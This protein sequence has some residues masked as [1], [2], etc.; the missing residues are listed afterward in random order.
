MEDIIN[1]GDINEII[2]NNIN[3]IFD[4][5]NY[6]LINKTSNK[7]FKIY[8]NNIKID[9]IPVRTFIN[10]TEC[11]VCDSKSIPL[12]QLIYRY[13]LVPHKCLIHCDKKKCYLSVVK[14][15]LMDIKKKNIYPFCKFT[16]QFLE[17]NKRTFR[18]CDE[19]NSDYI[20]INS[21]KKYRS[22]WYVKY[23]FKEKYY[24]IYSVD[25]LINYNLFR[26]FLK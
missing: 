5:L 4:I 14:R 7:I 22:K 10:I 21:L 18:D 1:I 9:I 24:K 25:N 13:D 20:H 3:T 2:F 17:D 23:N 26:W 11:N 8:F 16:D 6:R 19:K 12:K 15:Y